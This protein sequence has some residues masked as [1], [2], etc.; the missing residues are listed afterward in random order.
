MLQDFL[1][2]FGLYGSILAGIS[3]VFYKQSQNAEDFMLGSRSL[4]Y[5]AT[6]IAA[7]SSDMSIWLFMGLPGIIYTQG[8]HIAWV[9]IGLVTG[10]F[11]SW[12]FVAKALR[13][14]TEK[15]NA[16]TL[17]TYLE[18]R[19][20]DKSG[21]LRILSSFLCLL[22][23][24]FYISSG[25]V[26]MGLMF[27][28]VFNID[29]HLGILI[30]LL[31]TVTYT[32]VGGFVGV[33]WCDLFQGLFLLCMIMLVPSLAFLKLPSLKAISMAA[34][35]KSVSLSLLPKTLSGLISSLLLALSWGLGYFGQPHILVN[36]MGIKNSKDISKAR[37]IGITWQIL[38]LGSS[39]GIGIIAIAYFAQPL[40]DPE[41]VFV[42]MVKSLFNPF[43]AGFVLCAIVAAGLTT[44]DTQI[45]VSA[46]TFANDF[47]KQY[48]HPKATNKEVL[49]ASKIGVLIMP[50][51]SYAVAF[52]KS[53][54]VYALVEYAWNGLGSSFGPVILLSLYSKKVTAN[55]A[56]WGMLVGGTVAALWPL[57][58]SSV[59][60][61]IPGFFSNLAILL[62]F[63]K[64]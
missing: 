33:A 45:L 60:S 34:K 38:T 26:G 61:M 22:F 20:D 10:M 18:N 54:S 43:I 64:K 8:M 40:A 30:A 56:F 6:A 46:S 58:G 9:P 23:F 5:V 28:N 11:C 25:L 2:A 14:E 59:P 13:T 17:S 62:I 42:T 55:G 51:F 36:F 19:F 27:E 37:N 57:V 49:R 21:K 15:Y 63:S 16:L 29:Y 47:Y 4:N 3:Y 1:C 48:L 52:N 44:I 53:A 31:T 35:L 50:L 7:H 32:F 12:T 24:T 41:L 39:L